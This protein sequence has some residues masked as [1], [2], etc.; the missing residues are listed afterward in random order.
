MRTHLQLAPAQ[1]I[2]TT[3]TIIVHLFESVQIF[4]Q[5]RYSPE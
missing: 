3:I 1:R 4:K 5:S 2:I